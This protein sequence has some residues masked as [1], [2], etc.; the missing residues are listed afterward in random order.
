VDTTGPDTSWAFV[1]DVT[2]GNLASDTDYARLGSI[3]SLVIVVGGL[4]DPESGDTFTYAFAFGTAKD[5]EKFLPF[6]PPQDSTKIYNVG[7]NTTFEP[8]I[9]YVTAVSACNRV[10]RCSLVM[11]DGITF[12]NSASEI[13]AM[14][15]G[16][17]ALDIDYQRNTTTLC[18]SWHKTSDAES[19][20]LYHEVAFG[21]CDSVEILKFVNVGLDQKF[22]FQELVFNCD[23]HTVLLFEPLMV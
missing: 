10:G 3:T 19:N 6:S 20:I 18:G 5:P 4:S 12:D 23:M 1:K 13:G 14:L 2:C 16:S 22:C 9:L 21:I 15:D 7:V 11:S 17:S 8:G